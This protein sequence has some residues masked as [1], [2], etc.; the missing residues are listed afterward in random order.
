E[1]T[2]RDLVSVIQK[3]RKDNG[4]N[5]TDRIAVHIERHPA[6]ELAVLQFASY[7]Q[8]E[9]LATSLALSDLVSGEA[10]ELNDDVTLKIE[11]AVV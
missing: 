9:V 5:V 3:L 6:I 1:G 2:A 11:V 4:F 10:V 8:E 7:I